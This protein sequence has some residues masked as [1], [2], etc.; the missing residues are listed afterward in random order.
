MQEPCKHEH[1]REIAEPQKNVRNGELLDERMWF[2]NDCCEQWETSEKLG[3]VDSIE[4]SINL[5]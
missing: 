5:K 1:R 4:L 2:C 3:D